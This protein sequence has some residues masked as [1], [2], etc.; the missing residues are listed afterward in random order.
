MENGG[1][2][3]IK[4]NKLSQSHNYSKYICYEIS[5]I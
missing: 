3:L 1:G 4:D 2:F 5:D